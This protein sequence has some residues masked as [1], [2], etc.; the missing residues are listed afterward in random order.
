M[1]TKRVKQT[2]DGIETRE[3]MELLVEKITRATITRDGLMAE[4]D[5]GL[6]DIRAR[7]EPQITAYGQE[8]GAAM[9]QAQQWAL[10]HPEEFGDRKSIEM[11]HGL[12]GFRTGTPK[13]KLLSGWTWE[14][15]LEF[16]S[17]N[18][19]MDLIRTKKEVDRELILANRDCIKPE[20]LKQI[21]IKVVQ[22]EAFFVEPKRD[23]L[24]LV[25]RIAVMAMLCAMPLLGGCYSP[26]DEEKQSFWLKQI[27]AEEKQQ[28]YYLE[29]IA[30]NTDGI[31]YCLKRITDKVSPLSAQEFVDESNRKLNEVEQ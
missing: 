12:V 22:D 23:D 11:V 16:I 19:L 8:I 30:K 13:L 29:R 2:V 7:F 28:T 25:K 1:T 31:P 5:E 17:V 18:Q 3:E 10:A 14:K 9:K 24:S 6:T 15:V 4:M 26:S 27:A 20:T 21:G